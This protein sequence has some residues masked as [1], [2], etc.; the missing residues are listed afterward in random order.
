MLANGSGKSRSDRSGSA[1]RRT[2]WRLLFLSTGETTLGDKLAE[3]GK[4]AK[5][6]QEVRLINISADA[7][8]GLGV[9][10]DLHG[11]PSAGDFAEHLKAATLRCYG[12]P[13]RRF[14]EVLTKRHAENPGAVSAFVHRTRNEFFAQ[15]LPAD[16]SPQV[17]SICTRFALIAAAGRLATAFGITG[18]P[19]DEASRGVGKCFRAWLDQRGSAGDH[20][21]EAGILQTGFLDVGAFGIETTPGDGECGRRR[22]FA[23]QT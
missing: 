1:R 17:R 20:E 9:F 21:I 23:W 6:G 22:T 18:W 7:G 3:V 4:R 15:H 5:A 14:L 13:S 2:T 19:A 12:A 16:A 10:E 11:S 8:A